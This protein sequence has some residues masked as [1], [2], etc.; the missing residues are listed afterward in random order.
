MQRKKNPQTLVI[1][2]QNHEI[3]FFFFAISQFKST[4]E[5]WE[6]GRKEHQDICNTPR[7]D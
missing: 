5:K 2:S 4:T 6:K 7:M 3:D 1:F